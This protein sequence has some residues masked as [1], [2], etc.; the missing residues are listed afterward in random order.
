MVC[1]GYKNVCEDRTMSLIISNRFIVALTLSLATSAA[2]AQSW[3]PDKPVEIV[4]GSGAGGSNDAV[5]RNIQ[6]I[7]QGAKLVT[8]PISVV[9]KPGGNQTVV[10]AYLNQHAGDGHYLDIG[11]PTLI[12]NEIMVGHYLDIGNPTL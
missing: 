2:S 10:L 8:P 1:F 6:R 5:A 4:V 11:N 9:N 7:M 12:G 3:Q